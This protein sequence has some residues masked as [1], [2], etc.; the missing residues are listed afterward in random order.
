MS[1]A[2]IT[3]PSPVTQLAIARRVEQI[4]RELPDDPTTAEILN[5]LVR[6]EAAGFERAMLQERDCALGSIRLSS[7]QPS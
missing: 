4:R 5:A 7:S 3:R 1:A 6:A 2:S